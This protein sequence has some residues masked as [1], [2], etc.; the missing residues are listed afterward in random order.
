ML[1]PIFVLL[2]TKFAAHLNKVIYQEVLKRKPYMRVNFNLCIYVLLSVTHLL[3]GNKTAQNC[4]L[5]K[6]KPFQ[7]NISD[8]KP[9][10]ANIFS[11]KWFLFQVEKRK[12]VIKI[13]LYDVSNQLAIVTI[14]L[15]KLTGAS[16]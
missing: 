11:K 7:K 14:P 10:M 6:C 2:T 1:K 4:S 12:F 8:S 16:R 3:Q 5:F 15:N 13:K 9:Y